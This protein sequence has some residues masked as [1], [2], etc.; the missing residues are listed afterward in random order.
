[1]VLRSP[2]TSR[3]PFPLPLL[4]ERHVSPFFTGHSSF[5]F[6]SSQSPQQECDGKSPRSAVSDHEGPLVL[7]I[8]EV[9]FEK[10]SPCR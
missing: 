1:M 4:F 3:L 8:V 5:V 7:A 6:G 2:P 10:P 9:G